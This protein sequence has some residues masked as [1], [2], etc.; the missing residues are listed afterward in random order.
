MACRFDSPVGRIPAITSPASPKQI[1]SLVQVHG[2]GALNFK[3]ARSIML[4]SAGAIRAPKGL[5]KT[6]FWQLMRLAASFWPDSASQFCVANCD[7]IPAITSPVDVGQWNRWNSE[8]FIRSPKVHWGGRF[9]THLQLT[10][11]QIANIAITRL[12]RDPSVSRR[13]KK[14]SLIFSLKLSQDSMILF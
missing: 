14:K 7:A 13:R 3:S 6:G 2:Q 12:H 11:V 4:R 1:P 5:D 10:E 9:I 8:R